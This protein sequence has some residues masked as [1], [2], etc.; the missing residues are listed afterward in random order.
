MWHR[1]NEPSVLWKQGTWGVASASPH[2]LCYLRIHS[3]QQAHAS[4]KRGAGARH[5]Q[6]GVLM[7]KHVDRLRRPKYHWSTDTT[8]AAS[9]VCH[10]PNIT[11]HE[12]TYCLFYWAAAK[13][14][15][16]EQVAIC[17]GHWST[18]AFGRV[19][20]TSTPEC[21]PT[22]TPGIIMLKHEE[23]TM[24]DKIMVIYVYSRTDASIAQYI[25]HIV[26]Y[27]ESI[28]IYSTGTCQH[29]VSCRTLSYIARTRQGAIL[30]WREAE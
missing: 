10:F 7:D 5:P 24:I 11:L 28:Y 9:L 29:N 15:Q 13:Q 17:F 27:I 23:C 19:A 20:M 12:C 16:I 2:L 22:H 14:L 3:G 8:I 21:T 18:L 4:S 6:K 26:L 30:G 1:T 25:K